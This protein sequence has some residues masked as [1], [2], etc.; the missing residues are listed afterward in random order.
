MIAFSRGT[1]GWAAFN[2]GTE[3]KQITVQTGMAK[4]RYCDAIH[5]S[6]VL[7]SCTGPTIRVNAAGRATVSVGAKDAVAFDRMDRL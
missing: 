6:P 7:N 4:G 1:R 2:N 5:G 3:A